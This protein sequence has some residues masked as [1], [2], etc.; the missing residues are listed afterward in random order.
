M[1]TELIHK[2]EEFGLT[3]NILEIIKTMD[4]TPKSVPSV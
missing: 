3:G 2:F 1:Q 4:V